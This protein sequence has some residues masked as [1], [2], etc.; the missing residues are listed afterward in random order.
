M[1]G[2]IRLLD[3]PTVCLSV[4]PPSGPSVLPSYFRQKPGKQY[5]FMHNFIKDALRVYMDCKD[6]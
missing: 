3:R 5:L 1:S 2:S 6:F 4:S